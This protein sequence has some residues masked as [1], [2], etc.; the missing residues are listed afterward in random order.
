MTFSTVDRGSFNMFMLGKQIS[1]LFMNFTSGNFQ[2]E[3]QN[4]LSSDLNDCDSCLH[5][6]SICRR[7]LSAHF[8]TKRD[9]KGQYIQNYFVDLSETFFPG[10]IF[11]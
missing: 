7:Q 1:Y 4:F 10:N 2:S 8:Y 6:K 9:I 3:K 11:S 5:L